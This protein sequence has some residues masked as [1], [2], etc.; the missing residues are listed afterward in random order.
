MSKTAQEMESEF[1]DKSTEFLLTLTA[2]RLRAMG[3]KVDYGG[4]VTA[5]GMRATGTFT[6]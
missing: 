4:V 1:P 3:I 6:G 2:D 5:L